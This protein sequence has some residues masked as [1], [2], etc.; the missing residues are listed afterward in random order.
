[1]AAEKD[2]LTPA[3]LKLIQDKLPKSSPYNKGK[4]PFKKDK[5]SIPEA[6]VNKIFKKFFLHH[7]SN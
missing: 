2:A 6:H 4:S 3:Q 1:M 7:V 5:L